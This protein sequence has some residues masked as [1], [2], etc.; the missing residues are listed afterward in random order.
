MEMGW[1]IQQPGALCFRHM[2]MCL[3]TK[4]GACE[5]PAPEYR[6]L[7]PQI[8]YDLGHEVDS[9]ATHTTAGGEPWPQHGPQISLSSLGPAS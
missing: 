7:C 2:K 6:T 9:G 5:C 1:L 4:L 3:K 8:A